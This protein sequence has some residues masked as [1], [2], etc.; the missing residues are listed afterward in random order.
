MTA[1]R[2]QFPLRDFFGGIAQYAFEIRLGIADPPLVDYITDLLTRFIR[3]DALYGMHNLSGNRLRQVGDM[4]AEADARVGDARREVHRHIGDF[5]LFWT[6]VYP[7]ALRSSRHTAAPPN[8]DPFVDF[9]TQGKP[10]YYIASTI[11]GEDAT[12]AI[13]RAGT[14]EPGI[15]DLA[16]GLNEARKEWERREPGGPWQLVVFE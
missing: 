6:G 10:A 14:P 15:R 12:G 16:Y 9:C 8:H 11:P 7:E 2:P 5:T 4:L 13:R 1:D 3:S